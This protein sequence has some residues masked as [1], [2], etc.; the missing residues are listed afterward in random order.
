MRRGG[1]SED[2]FFSREKKSVIYG[3]HARASRWAQAGAA[4][5]AE[6]ER[7]LRGGLSPID[8]N[9]SAYPANATVLRE[10]R[11]PAKPSPAN[12]R[13]II[14]QVEGSGMALV[15]LVGTYGVA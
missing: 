9:D 2:P 4:A 8:Q 7:P 15:L 13:S 1:G 10:P 12:P 5:D 6:Q 11:Q 14:A 3:F